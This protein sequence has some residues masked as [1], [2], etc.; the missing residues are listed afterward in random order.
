[1]SICVLEDRYVGLFFVHLP[2]LHSDRLLP[3]LGAHAD[4][5][6]HDPP[7]R[8]VVRHLHQTSGKLLATNYSCDVLSET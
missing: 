1:M 4:P 8:P 7:H 2:V 6:H 5:P 3:R